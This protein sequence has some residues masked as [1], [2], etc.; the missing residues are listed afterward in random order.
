MLTGLQTASA[1]KEIE[2][3]SRESMDEILE[4]LQA[5]FS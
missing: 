1:K 3:I 2:K 5:V 4:R